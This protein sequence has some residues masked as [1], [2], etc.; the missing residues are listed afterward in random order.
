MNET[1]E[2]GIRLML[3]EGEGQIPDGMTI[4]QA[5]EFRLTPGESLVIGR[6]AGVD[7]QV[8][9]PSVGMR[10]VRLTMRSKGIWM[11]D[12]GSGGGSAITIRGVTTPRPFCL[13]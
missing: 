1:D 6:A 13:L 5:F 12:L 8:P 2:V 3:V 4:G 9:A 11:E 10:V 7:F